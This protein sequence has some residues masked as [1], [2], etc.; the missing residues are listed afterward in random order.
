MINVI[1]SKRSPSCA[2]QA[3]LAWV[4]QKPPWI[5][6]PACLWLPSHGSLRADSPRCKDDESTNWNQAEKYTNDLDLLACHPAMEKHLA[7]ASL[8]LLLLLL[9]LLRCCCCCYPIPLSKYSKIVSDM[10]WLHTSPT[11][12]SSTTPLQQHQTDPLPPCHRNRWL[13][14]VKQKSHLDHT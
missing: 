1:H 10:T 9:L 6:R 5:T 4:F 13:R 14:S 7:V 8:L 2:A 3:S 12:Q 11:H